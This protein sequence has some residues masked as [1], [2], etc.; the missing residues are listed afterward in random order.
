MT[1]LAARIGDPEAAEQVRTRARWIHQ[2]AVQVQPGD[3]SPQPTVMPPQ[4]PANGEL[5]QHGQPWQPVPAATVE[6]QQEQQGPMIN[7]PTDVPRGENRPSGQY[8]PGC[9]TCSGGDRPLDV[10]NSPWTLQQTGEMRLQP[11]PVAGMQEQ[12]P[13][14]QGSVAPSGSSTQSGQAQ[15]STTPGANSGDSSGDGQG[16]QGGT[17]PAAGNGPPSQPNGPPPRRR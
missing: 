7:R 4:T 8:G 10:P 17:P 5:N 6:P 11:S 13:A 3:P 14:E 2:L 16:G 12:Q 9:T 1:Q 15:P